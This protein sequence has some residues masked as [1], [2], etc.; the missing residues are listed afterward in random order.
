MAVQNNKVITMF[1]VAIIV[2]ASVAAIALY[3]NDKNADGTT[4]TDMRGRTVTVPNDVDKV[5][6]LSA[7]SL[8]FVEY[9]GAVDMVVGIDN[10]D[11]SVNARYYKATYRIAHDVTGITNVGS[12]D[13]FIEIIKTGAQLIIS[14]KT[15]KETL[16]SLQD[17]T[18]IPVIGIN[19]E[20]SNTVG[21]EV[22]NKNIELL[23]KVLGKEDRARE[24][25]DGVASMVSE[26]E[27]MR[28]SS[29]TL[30]D[31]T[32]YIGGMFY[33][34]E[35]GL[36]RT[37][38][39]FEPFTLVGVTNVMPD[40]NNGNPYTTDNKELVKADP[41]YIFI[42][43]M[44]ADSTSKQTFDGERS[45]LEGITAVKD[46]NIYSLYVEKYYGTN[47]ES[48][49]MNAYYIGNLLDPTA[50]DYDVKEK[51][52]AVL[53]LFYIGSDITLDDLVEKQGS[54]VGKLDW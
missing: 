48:E 44:T 50:F 22:F 46:G 3:N 12:E 38:G 6:C 7:G 4:V 35:G 14:S 15:D 18:G 19:A 25:I 32:C 17:K 39:N 10:D 21:G 37:S 26:I 54:G 51:M 47:W 23:G 2:I 24:L 42:D 8:R 20:G 28:D 33:Y 13:S 40:N 30:G 49:L 9:M 16:D 29:K 27:G 34:K 5:V 11:S 31:V 43:S 53:R 41:E 52:G 36:Y 1:I 45:I